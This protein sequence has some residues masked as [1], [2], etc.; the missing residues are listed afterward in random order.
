MIRALV[1][2]ELRETWMFVALALAI[3]FVYLSRLT[4][5]WSGLMTPLVGWAPGMNAQKP[6]VPFVQDSFMSVFLFT[7]LALAITLGFRQSAWEPSQGTSL[8]LLHLPLSRRGI[9]VTKL[10]T[11]TGLL[12]LCTIAPILIYGLWAATPG[13]HA[14]PFQWSMVGPVFRSWLLL[15]LVYI[16]AFGSGIQPARWFGSR[17]LPLLSVAVPAIIVSTMPHWWLL[18][19]PLLVAVSA[20]LVSD[21]LLEVATRDF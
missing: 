19:F 2:K 3:Y 9:F 14:G 18:A 12:M 21:V 17:L 8:Y 1:W 20:I 10:M 7:A 13:T 5:R 6:D 16:G 11:G 15:P 4:D